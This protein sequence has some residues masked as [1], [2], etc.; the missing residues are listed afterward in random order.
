MFQDNDGGL[1]GYQ[2]DSISAQAF[3]RSLLDEDEQLDSDVAVAHDLTQEVLPTSSF[4]D[5]LVPIDVV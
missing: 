3:L 5:A 1:S 4:T 2:A